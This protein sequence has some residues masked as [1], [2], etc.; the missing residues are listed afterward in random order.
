MK[1]R[2]FL[3]GLIVAV[4]CFSSCT[5]DDNGVTPETEKAII[6]EIY[7]SLDQP[8]EHLTGYLSELGFRESAKTPSKGTT[9]SNK[10]SDDTDL[11]DDVPEDYKR[12]FVGI[13]YKDSSTITKV[14]YYRYVNNETNPAAYCKLFS[15]MIA[16]YGYSDWKGY[17]GDAKDVHVAFCYDEYDSATKAENREDLYNHVKNDKL[18]S[19][20]T[21]QGVLEVFTYTHHDG[22]LWKGQISIR[23]S[24]YIE[25]GLNEEDGETQCR[26]ISLD[27]ILT[28]I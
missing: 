25:T 20:E 12:V 4:V 8:F 24:V 27:F 11:D 9:Y 7:Q 28:R 5:H 23:S 15:D 10:V 17:Y 26:D 3:I 14:D 18:F 22:S 21:D 13:N 2:L 19:L 1:T 6:K 16:S